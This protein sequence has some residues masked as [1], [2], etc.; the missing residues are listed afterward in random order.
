MSYDV[1]KEKWIPV[2]MLDGPLAEMSVFEVL[3]SAHKI[4]RITAGR[5]MFDCSILTFLLI[6][7]MMSF[8]EEDE[9]GNESIDLDDYIRHQTKF[10]P[11]DIQLVKDF[12]K[13]CVDRGVSFDL[14]DPDRPFMQVWRKEIS[15]KSILTAAELDAA[16]PKGNNVTFYSSPYVAM[17]P[18]D[19]IIRLITSVR[20]H[21]YRGAGWKKGILGEPQTYFF[22]TGD[23]LYETLVRSIMPHAKIPGGNEK[24]GEPW[25]VKMDQI[26]DG[27]VF[28]AGTLGMLELMTYPVL[29]FQV[30]Q[31]LDGK[32]RH[33]YKVKGFGNTYLNGGKIEDTYFDPYTARSEP[34]SK[35]KKFSV[36]T[37]ANGV[38]WPNFA[39]LVNGD[40]TKGQ[41]AQIIIEV[42]EYLRRDQLL[43][44]T[45]YATKS[46]Q[47]EYTSDKEFACILRKGI[48]SNDPIQEGEIREVLFGA[49]KAPTSCMDYLKV[50]AGTLV[51]AEASDGTKLV[52][53]ISNENIY[54]DCSN[55]FSEMIASITDENKEEW[56]RKWCNH[57]IKACVQEWDESISR[58]HLHGI[59]MLKCKKIRFRLEE[60]LRNKYQSA[61]DSL[62]DTP[63]EGKTTKK[64]KKEK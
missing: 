13:R 12:V 37:V 62:K 10:E 58:I 19:V 38:L 60:N 25:W 3:E 34:K 33:V 32:V 4:R 46:N 42:Q 15:D 39:A 56:Q 17:E 18:K 53:P 45:I 6:I 40:K 29:A 5:P 28:P 22:P 21:L 1:L 9:N 27:K 61:L 30:I 54:I 36:F 7:L 16:L 59:A 44:V 63:E 8:K 47:A 26:E 50:L 51:K 57:V 49:L 41:N 14:F 48:L 2:K 64:E 24:Y 55:L 43:H 20:Y 23:N 52:I 11:E 31:D 35:E